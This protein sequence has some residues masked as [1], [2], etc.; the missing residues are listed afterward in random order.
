[1]AS[2][3]AAAVV[4][5]RGNSETLAKTLLA[6]SNQQHPLQQVVIVETTESV[7]CQE[8]AKSFGF[9]V[10]QHQTDQ[11]GTA[12]DAGVNA[13][14]GSSNWLW[15]LHHDTAPEPDA[16]ASLAR[17]AEISP[18]VAVI[19]P[20]Q[21]DWDHPIQIRQLG[22]T[23]TRTAR[24]FTLV[25][26]EY[27]QGQ[28]DAS[29]DTLA[30]STAGMLV[31]V[32]LW[33]KLGGIDET[34]PSYAQDI[35][36]CIKA[37]ALGYRVIVEPR[38]R[39]LTTGSLTTNLHSS[40]KLFGGR[41]EALAK[42]HVHLATILWPAGLLPLLYLLMPL[43][44]ALSIPINLLQKR[45]ARIV[46]QLSAWLYSWFTISKRLAA[47]GRVRTLGSLTSLSKLYATSEQVKLRRE[48]RFEEEPEPEVRSKGIVESGAIWL[49]LIPMLFSFGLIPLGAV[50]RDGLAPV[51]RSFEAIWD[52]VAANTQ[53]YLDGVSLPSD[54]FNWFWATLGFVWPA[55]PVAAVGWYLL[56]APSLLFIG[57]WLL[58]GF[59]S[60]N[61]WVRNFLALFAALLPAVLVTQR[62]AGIVE[63]TAVIFGVWTAF[64]IVKSANSFNLARSWRWLGLAG[65]SGAV[66][67][68]SS[69]VLF[70]IV[71]LLSLVL[72]LFKIRRLGVLVWFP[73]PGIALL[74]PWL[75]FAFE[76]LNPAFA[77]VTSAASL[78]PF[79]PYEDP[80]W[81]ISLAVVAVLALVAAIAHPKIGL[82]IWLLSIALIYASSFQP[83]AGSH[84]LVLGGLLTQ[85]LLIGY[86]LERVKSASLQTVG[87][88]SLL[89]AGLASGSLS[90]FQ[91]LGFEFSEERQVPALVMAQSDIDASVRTLKIS[92][93]GESFEAEL[94]WGDGRN[95]NERSVLFDYVRPTSATEPALAQLAGSLVA[96]N[97]EGVSELVSS[98]GVDFVLID[99]SAAKVQVALDSLTLLQ[100]SG[101]T[102]FGLLWRVVEPNSNP[103]TEIQHFGGRDLQLGLLAAFLLLAIPTPG[104]ITGRRLRS[105]TK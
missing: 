65:L 95:Q 55:S 19:G 17:A 37:R 31:A 30:V 71:V 42:A 64:F 100:A 28:F 77:T 84:A 52:S 18:S 62:V 63:L 12:I 50:T 44:V 61:V 67:A 80:W 83:I 86:A 13:L 87:V 24:P 79:D 7:D 6:L 54:P 104:S 82:S 96:G 46:G 40:K 75:S 4:I 57:F 88:V 45:P 72:G 23:T 78:Q 91:P 102:D 34:S 3:L 97:P 43:V 103:V 1:M 59:V 101:Q 35:E 5:S 26:D 10:V 49:S 89:L 90:I 48:R 8:L 93:V 41:A 36:F 9:G 69:P 105:Q 66:V 76:T 56:F 25:E 58:A 22:L 33:Q 16:L 99:Q 68:V 38:A 32:G 60:Q 73:L 27:D 2:L 70:A 98:L 74:W 85:L 39:I 29:G 53:Q 92:A 14:Q 11:V 21:L 20:K 94:V 81:L 51:S 47:R 15:I